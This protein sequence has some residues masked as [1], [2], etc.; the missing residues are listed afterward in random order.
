[1]KNMYQ[2]EEGQIKVTILT[3]VYNC[4]ETIG[5]TIESVL[6]QTYKNL[7]YI[8]LD[9]GSS[10]STLKI[11]KSYEARFQQKGMEYVIISEPDHGNYDAL[12]KGAKLAT[13][14]LVGNIN[15][16]DWYEPNAVTEM[17]LL[18]EKESYD[19][20][21]SSICINKNSRSFVKHAYIGRLWTTAGF[22][23]PTMFAKKSI[24]EKYPYA[25]KALDDDFDMVTR[26]YKGNAK[27]CTLD[28]VLA[29]YSL[30]GMST[31]KSFSN[32]RERIHMKY[33]TY[34]RN[35]FSSFYW[36]YCVAVELCKFVLG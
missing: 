10:D 2:S 20:A 13:G 34:K 17:V 36:M 6:N 25:C 5:R 9:G 23:H 16:D 18:Y 11:A 35:G 3:P 1:M 33:A 24:L 7:E 28:K 31:Q 8:L 12:N 32:M 19:L 4:E 22:C 21:W 14:E 26:A 27:I 30:G 29:N 15:A